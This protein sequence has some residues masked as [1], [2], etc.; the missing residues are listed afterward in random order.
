VQLSLDLGYPIYS[1]S[2]SMRTGRDRVQVEATGSPVTIGDA[3]VVPGDLLRGDADGVVVIPR[4]HEE[5]VLAV[6]EEI[7]AAEEQIRA[8]VATGLRLDEA[9]RRYKYHQL[10]R[11]SRP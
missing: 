4:V 1:R 9:R 2:Y 6:A 7:E 8:A 5:Q 3:R 11:G 10:Q